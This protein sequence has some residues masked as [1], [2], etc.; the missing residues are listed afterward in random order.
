MNVYETFHILFPNTMYL[1]IKQSQMVFFPHLKKHAAWSIRVKGLIKN[2]KVCVCSIMQKS[3]RGVN[4]CTKYRTW[5]DG[6]CFW[7]QFTM[8]D[9]PH[10]MFKKKNLYPKLENLPLW[11]WEHN[12]LML[13]LD[14]L[15]T[16]GG[17]KQHL[18][19]H[20]LRRCYEMFIFLWRFA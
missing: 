15:C 6:N 3:S 9:Y 14:G 20:S 7:K 8:K 19:I 11:E 13:W 17:W 1:E 16:C 12:G 10:Y 4:I 5:T 2:I 18:L